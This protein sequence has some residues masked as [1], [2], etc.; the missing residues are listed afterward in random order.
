MVRAQNKPARKLILVEIDPQ[1][2]L[3]M[4]IAMTVVE[5]SPRSCSQTRCRKEEP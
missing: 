3:D 1:D 2:A 4:N 5:F